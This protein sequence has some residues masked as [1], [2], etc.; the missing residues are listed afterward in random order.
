MYLEGVDKK[1][2]DDGR[3]NLP[4]DEVEDCLQFIS[5]MTTAALKYKAQH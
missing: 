3:Y 5:N 1:I 4:P 2:N